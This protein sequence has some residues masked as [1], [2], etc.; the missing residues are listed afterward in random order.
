MKG[1]LSHPVIFG[2]SKDSILVPE[3]MEQTV[4]EN[5]NWFSNNT[6][7]YSNNHLTPATTRVLTDEKGHSIKIR[8]ASPPPQRQAQ[9]AKLHQQQQL[10]QKLQLAHDKDLESC[11]L[12]LGVKEGSEKSYCDDDFS[13]VTPGKIYRHPE[14]LE[15]YLKSPRAKRTKLLMPSERSPKL[16]RSFKGNE[17]YVRSLSPQPKTWFSCKENQPV[18]VVSLGATNSSVKAREE[19]V[20]QYGGDNFNESFEL[21]RQTIKVDEAFEG[22]PASR[23]HSS[24]EG[25]KEGKLP[26]SDRDIE[27][28][29]DLSS[30]GHKGRRSHAMYV[31]L[32]SHHCATR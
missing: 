8:V 19:E 13:R 23:Q 29:S 21:K 10:Q 14:E 3:I 5:P 18:K 12:S 27:A 28:S 1:G 22:E 17:H 20:T 26:S 30:A 15:N 16:N 9:L 32:C 2:K 6:P 24:C 31:L 7:N 11:A 25:K 4:A